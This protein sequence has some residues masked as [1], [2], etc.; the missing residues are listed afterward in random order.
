MSEP[1]V[2]YD[3]CAHEWIIKANPDE[4]KRVCKKCGKRQF[5]IDVW[6]NGE[7]IDECLM[8]H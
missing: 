6:D 7:W 4:V 5:A 1:Q 2:Q 3:T 8:S